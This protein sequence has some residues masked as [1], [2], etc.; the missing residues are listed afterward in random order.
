M[1]STLV[2]IADALAYLADVDEDDEAAVA[3]LT[4]L[5][6]D[7]EATFLAQ[8]GRPE[9]AFGAAESG[10]EEVYDGNGQATLYLERNIEA[11]T[12]VKLGYDSSD[13]DE[14]L[15]VADQTEL[16]W[17]AGDN[18]LVRLDGGVFGCIGQ[19]NFVEVT[20][21]AAAELPRDAALAITNA[22]A[23]IWRKLGSEGVVSE[24]TGPYEAQY[25]EF[26]G[27]NGSITTGDPIWRAA[28]A[29]HRVVRV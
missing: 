26:L 21:D 14:T 27:G 17:R 18:R 11:L 16:N 22:V 1:T 9:Q 6:D 28:I 15:D 13:P 24:R 10:R 20:Y 29:N 25:A 7:V 12:S 23:T 2:P 5:V 8:C 3:L 4:Q 19:P